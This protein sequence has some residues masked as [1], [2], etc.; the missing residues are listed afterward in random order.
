MADGSWRDGGTS[1]LR[2]NGFTVTALFA[3]LHAVEQ[4][5]EH[6]GAPE[7][8]FRSGIT[9]AIAIGEDTD[10]VAAIAGALLG[11]KVGA[12][13]IPGAW[14]QVVHGWPGMDAEDPTRMAGQILRA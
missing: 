5:R 14:R 9:A 6:A 8:A 4:A 10:T 11:A 2:G 12:N 1:A 7:D 3:A 13:V